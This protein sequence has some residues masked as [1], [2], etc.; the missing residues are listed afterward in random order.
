MDKTIGD[1]IAILRKSKNLS[2]QELSKELCVSNKTISKWE[3]GNSIP[4]VE[5]LKKIA[6]YFNV[7]LDYFVDNN[8]VSN[9]NNQINRNHKK[10]SL[11]TLIISLS[12]SFVVVLT[13]L[14]TLLIP[15]SPSV[16]SSIFQ[17]NNDEA[18]MAYI[19]SNSEN[20]FSFNN[21]ID[22]PYKNTWKLYSDINAT[23]EITSNVVEL[24]EGDNTFYI[25]V[26]NSSNN[27]KLYTINIRRKPMYTITFNSNGGTIC[28]SVKIEEGKYL[29]IIP[30]SNKIGYTF[31]GWE[32]NFSQP[33]QENI[34]V[35][36]IWQ[37]NT[38]TPY[39]VEYYKENVNDNNYSLYYTEKLEG[40]SDSY[41]ETQIINYEHFTHL[42][43]GTGNGY[44]SPNGTS[45]FRH[46][47]KR[48]TYTVE[49][50]LD[51]GSRIGGCQL[52][53]TVKYEAN[54]IEPICEKEGYT[55]KCYNSQFTNI[56][57]NTTIFAQYTINQYSIIFYTN[58]GNDLETIIL[59]F[60]S[61][62]NN[63][64]EP[65][66]T[67]YSFNGWNQT[68]PTNMPPHDLILYARWNINQY[69]I[70]FETLGG[71]KINSITQDYNT[72][73]ELI[74]E[75][76]IKRGYTFECWDK[77]I[78][79][80]M[81]AENITITAKWQA[82]IYEISYQLDFGE[83]P[84]NV[85]TFT[86]EDNIILNSPAERD[87]YNFNWYYNDEIITELNG[88]YSENLNLIGVW[89]NSIFIIDIANNRIQGLTDYGKTLETIDVTIMSPDIEILYISQG[90]F[91]NSTANTFVL[92]FVGETYNSSHNIKYIFGNDNIPLASN[93]LN[94]T[95]T[96]DDI[97]DKDFSNC[98]DIETI[99]IL[100][101]I[102]IGY[103]AFNNCK[104]LLTIQ[105]GNKLKIIN[106][107]AF[108]N[109]ISLTEITI[110]N[111]VETI[112]NFI[113]AY[114]NKLCRVTI[115]TN[116]TTISYNSFSLCNKLVEI[117]NLSSITLSYDKDVLRSTIVKIIHTSLDDE[118]NIFIIDNFQYVKNY[119]GK[120]YL[121]DYLGNEENILLPSDFYYRI[122]NYAFEDNTIIRNI[123]IP[124]KVLEIGISAF[125]NC[126]N[127]QSVTIKYNSER[128]ISVNAF[129]NCINL[130][131]VYIIKE[132]DSAKI[133]LLD[134]AFDNCNNLIDILL[135][136]QYIAYDGGYII[137]NNTFN[138]CSH[139]STIYFDGSSEI[140]EST[141]KKNGNNSLNYAN[142]YFYSEQQ[143]TNNGNYWHLVND[144]P[145]V[146]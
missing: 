36:A 106:D 81:P 18:T 69:T 143:P 119:Q 50:N 108:A 51:G 127:L 35:D 92:P 3:C 48:N 129:K 97:S 37:A 116:V 66:K 115:G 62:I 93:I 140:W 77:T 26:T 55:F 112:G 124:S 24:N 60:N 52:V 67:G 49:F 71:S 19:V 90:A 10:I 126:K 131:H 94:I 23:N 9:E 139:L 47:Y 1:K 25:L 121:I 16:K 107:N 58:G 59:D 132:N 14:L 53:Q 91:S 100:N 96:N 101:A 61:Q 21:K 54:A 99:T 78:P 79:V 56:S 2:Q 83:M 74:P 39:V 68:I 82:I 141:N 122:A 34:N 28:S 85:S 84:E 128:T 146:W 103:L 145:T 8:T 11:K 137:E 20:T 105:L 27:K 32:Y 109:C 31:C 6:D 88:N 86:V 123:I 135:P 65:I 7:S 45:I 30:E 110:P 4:D 72:N 12:V 98:I 43:Y 138:N 144:Q 15:R 63:I 57:D 80:K 113:F 102:S 117:Y 75:N 118:S 120:I 134:G 5:T 104:S 76:P 95:I 70:T 133:R 114:C 38:N 142:I 130:L 22:V 64:P 125:Q 87:Y 29:Q 111:S 44:I 42:N 46:Y 17:I 136:A 33:I 73:I 13:I 89:T 41:I 40:T